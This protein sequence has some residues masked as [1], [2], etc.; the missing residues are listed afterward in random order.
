MSDF[1]Q[2]IIAERLG[3]KM[4]GKDTKIYKFEKIKRAKRAALEANPGAELIDMGVG[5]PDDMADASIVDVLCREA[6]K[7]E[8]RFYSDNGIQEFKD[9]ASEYMK[10]RFGVNID[11]V[12]EVNH[13]IGSKPALALIPFCLINPGDYALMTVPGYPVTVQSPNISAV[14]Y[15]ICHCL[16]KTTF[17][18][19]RRCP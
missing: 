19:L 7:K 10:N 15:I 8:N 18:G 1:M 11:P 17:T 6:R 16:R 14:K 2:N 5:E 3:G 12:N 4:F 9:A 13:S